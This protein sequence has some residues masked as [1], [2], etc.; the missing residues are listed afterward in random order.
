MGGNFYCDSEPTTLPGQAEVPVRHKL[1]GCSDEW[2]PSR[3]LKLA[4]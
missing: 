2:I 4:N 3:L 1:A